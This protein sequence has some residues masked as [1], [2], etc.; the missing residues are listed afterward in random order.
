[1]RPPDFG[2]PGVDHQSLEW[3][4][5]RSASRPAALTIYITKNTAR[6]PV[7]THLERPRNR[8]TRALNPLRPAVL[9]RSP[10]YEP[11]AFKSVA[12]RSMT[13][14]HRAVQVC[15]GRDQLPN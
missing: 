14:K 6:L 9:Q 11:H 4:A 12:R 2:I 13:R 10:D 5:A 3:L 8:A 15:L 1:M 7:P